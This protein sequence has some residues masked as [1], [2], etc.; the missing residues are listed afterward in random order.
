MNDGLA[1]VLAALVGLVGAVGGAAIGGMAATRGARVGAETAARA[2]ARQVQDQAAV[3]HMH[4]LRGQRLQAYQDLLAAYDA[5]S[6]AVKAVEQWASREAGDA[7]RRPGEYVQRVEA[8][9]RAHMVIRLVGPV[10]ARTMSA[11]LWEALQ[12]HAFK[13]QDWALLVER[14]SGDETIAGA[15]E[16]LAPARAAMVDAHDVFLSEATRVVGTPMGN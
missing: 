14:R 5:Y 8:F 7:G 15:R 10:E 1:A 6:D 9:L 3:D 4:W 2:T 11:V 13:L 12:T 16:E